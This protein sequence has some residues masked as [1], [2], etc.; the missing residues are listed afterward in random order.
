MQPSKPPRGFTVGAGVEL[1]GIAVAIFA[2]VVPYST[3]G[4]TTNGS[5]IV[6]GLGVGLALGGLLMHAARI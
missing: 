4:P 5:P 2:L 6:A 3:G 1:L